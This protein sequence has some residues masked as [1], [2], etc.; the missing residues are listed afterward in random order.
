MSLPEPK[1]VVQ[2]AELS[3][4]KFSE[5]RIVVSA[6]TSSSTMTALV[7][8]LM[9]PMLYS[10]APA[11]AT[12]QVT[13]SLPCRMPSFTG[14]A[15]LKSMVKSPGLK[16]ATGLA[17]AAPRRLVAPDHDTFTP[18]AAALVLPRRVRR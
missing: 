14:L 16:V 5:N 17:G 10:D 3:A 12:L 4:L 18:K 8:G 13:V 15:E 1:L 6:G 9:V 11:A 2:F 7:L